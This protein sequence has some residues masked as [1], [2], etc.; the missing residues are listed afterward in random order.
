MKIDMNGLMQTLA[1]IDECYMTY[2]N[3]RLMHDLTIV[4]LFMNAAAF[5]VKTGINIDEAKVMLDLN[6]FNFIYD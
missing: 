1:C 5:L 2:S 6:A 3:D 4:C